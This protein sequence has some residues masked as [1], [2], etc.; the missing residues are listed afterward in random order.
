MVPWWGLATKR[1]LIHALGI[2][3]AGTACLPKGWR[4]SEYNEWMQV[5]GDSWF[6][7]CGVGCDRA[8]LTPHGANSIA[9]LKLPSKTVAASSPSDKDKP[10]GASIILNT[11]FVFYFKNLFRKDPWKPIVDV[12]L[13]V[14]SVY[15]SDRGLFKK[16]LVSRKL[17]KKGFTHFR[18]FWSSPRATNKHVRQARGSECLLRAAPLWVWVCFLVCVSVKKWQE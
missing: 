2:Y 12:R 16:K 5:V 10:P 17:K 11:C 4:E 9:T 6:H 8:L 3:Q 13:V 7:I 15:P 14:W 1:K 18:T